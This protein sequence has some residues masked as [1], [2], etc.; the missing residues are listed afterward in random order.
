[1]YIKIL[2]Q[3]MEHINLDKYSFLLANQ[4]LYTY[5]YVYIYICVYIYMYMNVWHTICIVLY[6]RLFKTLIQWN[7]KTQMWQVYE[8]GYV[9]YK[10]RNLISNMDGKHKM[11]H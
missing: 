9:Q 2:E 1:M 11:P 4:P 5:T 8:F 7:L 10:S 3:N 6:A